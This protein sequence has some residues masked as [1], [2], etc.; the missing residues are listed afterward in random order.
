MVVNFVSY[1]LRKLFV[2]NVSFFFSAN[3]ISRNLH[4]PTIYTIFTWSLQKCKRG[5]LLYLV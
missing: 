1:K 4:F 2:F 3:T 5:V